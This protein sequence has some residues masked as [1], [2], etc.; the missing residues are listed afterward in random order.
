MAHGSQH[1]KVEN[2]VKKEYP[3]RDLFR[4]FL[5]MKSIL[6]LVLGFIL[7]YFKVT[8]I[9]GFMVFIP[10]QYISGQFYCTQFKVPDYLMDKG[11][12]FTTQCLPS[13]GLFLMVWIITYTMFHG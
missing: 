6:A 5:V 13:F 9:L 8:G 4:R 10:F 3:M 1:T 7:G 12:M 11:E 2:T